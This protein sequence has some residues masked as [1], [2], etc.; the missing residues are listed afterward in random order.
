MSDT[1]NDNDTGDTDEI[2]DPS[3]PGV[4][5][6]VEEPDDAVPPPEPNEPA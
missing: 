4:G 2:E 6:N 3:A 5:V 1:P